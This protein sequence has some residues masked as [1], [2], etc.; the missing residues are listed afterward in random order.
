VGDYVCLWL[1]VLKTTGESTSFTWVY[2]ATGTVGTG[3]EHCVLTRWSSLRLVFSLRHLVETFFWWWKGGCLGEW[4]KWQATTVLLGTC[5][6]GALWRYSKDV[7]QTRP[8]H[9]LQGLLTEWLILQSMFAS[10]GTNVFRMGSINVSF[11]T[12]SC[13]CA[14]VLFVAGHVFSRKYACTYECMNWDW[15]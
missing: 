14:F 2:C 13:A 8:V 6:R 10:L 1:L 12:K 4:T 11:V 5:C 15:L 3:T 9:G 7:V